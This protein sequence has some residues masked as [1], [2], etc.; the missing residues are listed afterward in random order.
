[1][2][3]MNFGRKMPRLRNVSELGCVFTSEL[4]SI[5]V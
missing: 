3:D 2:D 5:L 1:M 4:Q